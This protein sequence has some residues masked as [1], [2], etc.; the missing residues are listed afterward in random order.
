M[1]TRKNN[2]L[3]NAQKYRLARWV[4]DVAA[5]DKTINSYQHAAE[6]ATAAL[7]F[8]ITYS[9]AENAFDATGTPCPRP[10]HRTNSNSASAHQKVRSVTRALISLCKALNHKPENAIELLKIAEQQG[11]EE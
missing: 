8:K 9:N 10:Q 1:T 4:E 2:A 5:N 11:W 6:L 7:G 3:S